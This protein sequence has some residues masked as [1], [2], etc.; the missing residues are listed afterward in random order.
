[1][2]RQ[3]FS[4]KGGRSTWPNRPVFVASMPLKMKGSAR[5]KHCSFG[6]DCVALPIAT[7][8]ST[9]VDYSVW[10]LLRN[11]YCAVP[12]GRQQ[13]VPP[14]FSPDRSAQRPDVGSSLHRRAG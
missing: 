4:E 14:P 9:R 10:L 5:S 2:V 1:M 6:N 7:G 12:C 8:S 11:S 13:G 3:V